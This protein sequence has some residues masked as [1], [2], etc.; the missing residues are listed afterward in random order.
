MAHVFIGLILTA[1]LFL[2]S[3]A[4]AQISVTGSQLSRN[5]KSWIARAIAIDGVDRFNENTVEFMKLYGAD[6]IRIFANQDFLDPDYVVPTGTKWF[7]QRDRYVEQFLTAVHLARRNDL[8][9]IIVMQAVNP[10]RRCQNGNNL[11]TD[12]KWPSDSS[13]GAGNQDCGASTS[14]AFHTLIEAKLK[15]SNYSMKNDPDVMFEIYNEPTSAEDE[16]GHFGGCQKS[17][18]D[19]SNIKSCHSS[20]DWKLWQSSHQSVVNDLRAFGA[21][22]V[23]LVGGLRWAS[24][25]NEGYTVS[26]PIGKLAYAVHPY[27]QSN[28]GKP[29]AWK[30][31]FGDFAALHPVIA[32]EFNVLPNIQF[33]RC[34]KD[35]PTAAS[36]LVEYLHHL[37]IGLTIWAY[38]FKDSM[39]VGAPPT[40]PSH[41]LDDLTTFQGKTTTCEAGDTDAA[42]WLVYNYFQGLGQSIPAPVGLATRKSENGA[43]LIVSWQSGGAKSLQYVI[44]I[45]PQGAP[46][47][48]PPE[49]AFPPKDTIYVQEKTSTSFQNLLPGTYMI[50]VW[51]YDPDRPRLYSPPA[52]V[53][54]I[55]Y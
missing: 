38:D 21:K 37:H 55:K 50:E 35:M 3:E 29:E 15:S 12:E 16:N 11:P 36:Q 18:T 7:V 49:G 23:V 39:F 43:S 10:T 26:D 17:L 2:Q 8:A 46:L 31:W 14:R 48:S 40:D 54:N 32:T 9:V 19:I 47:Y 34:Y 42:G 33:R 22:N 53:M 30:A 52:I 4:K 25:F 27:L 51:S 24:L 13:L 28:F 41:S 44:A 20:S 1:L 45:L 6:T 5:G